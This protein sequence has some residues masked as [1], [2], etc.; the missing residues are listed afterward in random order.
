MSDIKCK[1]VAFYG[2]ESYDLIHYLTRILQALGKRCLVV[3]RTED[4]E[5]L[6]SVPVL[7]GPGFIDYRGVNFTDSQIDLNSVD[8]DYVFMYYRYNFTRIPSSIEEA[9]FV[10]DCQKQSVLGLKK[11][12]LGRYQFRA[13]VVRN[14]SPQKNVLE[15]I[16]MEL[17][18]LEFLD[19]NTYVLPFNPGDVAAMLSVQYDSTF[20]FNMIS[21]EVKNFLVNFCSVDFEEKDVLQALR[22]T[23]K[24]GGK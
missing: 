24:V 11:A 22:N 21:Q 7:D 16:K 23:M 5:M 1:I 13:L 12:V 15:Y 2:T 17:S 18:H 19:E 9:Y 4:R 20:Q 6:L 10:T 14:S 3:D 8:S